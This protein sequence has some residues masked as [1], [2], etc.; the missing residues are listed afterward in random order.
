MEC[1]LEDQHGMIYQ[2]KILGIS[3]NWWISFTTNIRSP[4]KTP[5]EA[6]YLE[7]GCTPLRFNL[8]TKHVNFLHYLLNLN[9]TELLQKV[10]SAQL[11]NPV[12]WDWVLQIIE[13]LKTLQ[14]PTDFNK[15]K[16]IS[17][18]KF[19]TMVKRNAKV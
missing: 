17:K 1:F 19:E 4:F 3:K 16:N 14:L 5:L 11:K 10:F 7:L 2:K 6:L 12:K 18:A 15:I 8:L 13:D 9:E